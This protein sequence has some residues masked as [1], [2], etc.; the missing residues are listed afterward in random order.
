MK[1]GMLHID[2]VVIEQNNTIKTV[3]SFTKYIRFLQERIASE[4]G[5]K[6]T[7]YR[8]IL[9]RFERHPELMQE[10]IDLSVLSQYSTLLELIQD[11]VSPLVKDD[12]KSLFG[13]SVPIAPQLFYCSDALYNIAFDEDCHFKQS[14]DR[15]SHEARA[16]RR[17]EYI[18]RFILER[19][20]NYQMATENEMLY[21]MCDKDSGLMRYFK[22]DLDTQFVDVQCDTALPEIDFE[23]F[24]NYSDNGY[25]LSLLQEIIPLSMF[26]LSGFSIVHITD[27]TASHAVE[28]LRN[29]LLSVA[30]ISHEEHVRTVS[31]TIKTLLQNNAVETGI[32]PL[33]KVN[34]NFVLDSKRNNTSLLVKTV[35]P[36]RAVESSYSMLLKKYVD[37]PK[38]LLV[39]SINTEA[40][41]RYPF[42]Q[43]LKD[44]GYNSYLIIPI[45]YNDILVGLLELATEQKRFLHDR[46]L[47]RLE[48]VIPLIAQ[49][50]KH[51]IDEFNYGIENIIKEKF[52]SLQPAVE[53][54]FNEVAWEYM[55]RSEQG[56]VKKDIANIFFK[57]VYP[58][59]GA[60]D[61]RNSSVERNLSLQQDL[62]THFSILAETLQQLRKLVPLALIDE[63]LYKC[64]K[65]KNRI[66]DYLTTDEEIRLTSFFDNEV[67]PFLEYFKANYASAEPV[68]N[69]Y[70][71]AINP[72]TGKAFTQRRK[73][74][75]AIQLINVT[76]SDYLE[77]QKDTLQQAYPNYF[78]KFRTD[79]IEYDIYIGQ[80]I[81]PGKQFDQLYLHNLRLW[82]ITSMAEI[83][84]LSHQLLPRME[85]QLFTTQLILA[86]TTPIDISFRND[87][88]RFDVEGAY[89]IRYEVVKKRIDKVHIKKTGER[90]TQPGTIA[91]V[92]YNNNDTTEYI[93]YIQ[94]LQEQNILDKTI[95]Y[96]DLEDLQG[97]SGLKA[98]RVTVLLD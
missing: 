75:D 40:L 77:K 67:K 88:R 19:L 26:S 61:I 89:N 31:L 92:Y 6:G 84:R 37:H 14:I 36:C 63:M 78:E 68:I 4:K 60:V 48:N 44:A 66:S 46:L 20:Y 43:P 93:K 94:Y 47:P 76:V 1:A 24:T 70:D 87:E 50:L 12:N 39:P 96:H 59:Y 8:F 56:Q 34:D 52:T 97:V 11:T 45:H 35:T 7:L 51:R 55:V 74:E 29:S 33:L 2:D 25:N 18:Y 32:L 65:W 38:P 17:V 95:E 69:A 23:L 83:A 80:S 22:L 27:V 71:E 5:I 58:L 62:F 86:H 90:L 3:V 72:A 42:L 85:K 13:L 79:G 54:R 53:W 98:I 81:S 57:D 64:N 91:L 9:R 21:S 15:I 10:E 49:I 82:Q 16:A 73:L 41:A 28:L 30:H